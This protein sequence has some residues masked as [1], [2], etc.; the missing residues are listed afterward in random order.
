VPF[1]AFV[2]TSGFDFVGVL[3]PSPNNREHWIWRGRFLEVSA[4]NA[5]GLVVIRNGAVNGERGR[6]ARTTGWSWSREPRKSGAAA[7]LKVCTF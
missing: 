3:V 6:T 7:A 5:A 1:W 2:Y 4:L